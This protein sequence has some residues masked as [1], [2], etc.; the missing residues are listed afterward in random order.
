MYGGS[1]KGSTVYTHLTNQIWLY[2]YIEDK[3]IPGFFSGGKNNTPDHFY[4][5]FLLSEG[6]KYVKVYR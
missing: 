2:K 3:H 5:S 6:V 1:I 4:R